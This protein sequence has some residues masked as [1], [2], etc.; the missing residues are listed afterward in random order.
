[1]RTIPAFLV[2]TLAGG[3]AGGA[4]AVLSASLAAPHP[5]PE[6]VA[7][8]PQETPPQVEAPT[9]AAPTSAALLNL[10][11]QVDDL[12]TRLSLNAVDAAAPAAA[13]APSQMTAEEHE[14]Q[15][16]KTVARFH[17]ALAQHDKDA[18]DPRWAPRATN[19]LKQDF[20][21]TAANGNFSVKAVDCR[22]TTCVADVDFKDRQTALR[23]WRTVL[24]A[25]RGIACSTQV[26]L[27]APTHGDD[28]YPTRVLMDCQD[29]REATN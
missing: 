21:R 20:E 4:V 3:L 12:R 23:S 24:S 29:D 13:D 1:M 27:D 26:V 16:Q 6:K 5:K 17:A 18:V 9:G 15:I 28:P 19:V 25:P 10:A 7:L 14:L 2:F 11:R 8:Q 22:T